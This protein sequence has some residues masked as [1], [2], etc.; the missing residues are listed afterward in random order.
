VNPPWL[1]IDDTVRE[2]AFM[3]ISEKAYWPLIALNRTPKIGKHIITTSRGI[4]VVE[5]S[6]LP[7]EYLNFKEANAFLRFE[8]IIHFLIPIIVIT[9]TS[10]AIDH[11]L[12]R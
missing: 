3:S 9:E 1:I 4:T 2:F 7:F 5:D 11:R 8:G 6:S 12:S 10:I